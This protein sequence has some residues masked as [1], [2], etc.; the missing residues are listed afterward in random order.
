MDRTPDPYRC[1]CFPGKIIS[2]A[3]WLY[4]TFRPSFRDVELLLAERV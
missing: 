4:H 3:V 2:H 1:H